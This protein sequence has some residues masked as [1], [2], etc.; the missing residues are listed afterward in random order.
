M[1]DNLLDDELTPEERERLRQ[2]P[3]VPAA[4]LAEMPAAAPLGKLGKETLGMP[5][6]MVGRWQGPLRPP[7]T[8]GATQGMPPITIAPPPVTNQADIPMPQFP[9]NREAQANVLRGTIASQGLGRTMAEQAAN[10]RGRLEA[11]G[12]GYSQIQNPFL[13]GLAHTAATAADILA[14][15]ISPRIPGTGMHHQML[16]AEQNARE[17]QGLGE[18]EKEAQTGEQQAR[19]EQIQA[20]TEAMKQP[21]PEQGEESDKKIGEYTN[22]DGHHVLIFQDNRTGQPYETAMGA[23]Q[24]KEPHLTE[25]QQDYQQYL[26]DNKLTDT[27]ANKEEFLKKRKQ[28]L[29]ITVNTGQGTPWQQKTTGLKIYQ[30]AM[31]ADFRAN[32]ME[33]NYKDALGGNQQAMVSLL[34]NHIGMTLGLQKGARI[35]KDILHEAQKSAPWLQNVAAR[36]SDQGYL[37]GVT[38]SPLAMAQMVELAR[39]QRQNA[40]DRADSE[41]TYMGIGNK[42]QS[43]YKQ[44]EAA[45]AGPKR[46]F[47]PDTSGKPEGTRGKFNGVPF[48]IIKGRM[49]EQ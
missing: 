39:Q 18:A 25:Q 31:D 16:I 3:A 10:E 41:A 43:T 5:E 35:T 37:E 17:A 38:L 34:T 40:W 28:D 23:A 7:A 46:D 48:T 33:Q 24:E 2:Q 8:V 45:Q 20:Q 30:P 36:F 49:V 4:M 15:R 42:P 26:K 1:A 32:Q 47:G 22:A 21:P 14:P 11:T 13:R 12:P 27:A 29:K 44:P 9:S 6:G 19:T